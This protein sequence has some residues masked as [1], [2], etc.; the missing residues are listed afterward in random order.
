M[1]GEPFDIKFTGDPSD[2]VQAAKQVA[3][4]T[5]KIASAEG[6]RDSIIS[7]INAKLK[8]MA[9]AAAVAAI[10]VA[11]IG[12]NT[13]RKRIKEYEELSRAIEI[14]YEKAQEL[15]I[16]ERDAKLET[17]AIRS[18]IEGLAKAQAGYSPELRRLGFTIAEIRGLKPDE[19]FDA[20]SKKLNEGGLS[21]R[22]F[23]AAI[24]VLG[25][26]GES[27][28][29]AL[30]GGFE[31][32]R[33]I[34]RDSGKII[35]EETFG[36]LISNSDT[37]MAQFQ[38]MG[39]DI[40]KLATPFE[41]F[42]ELASAAIG[43]VTKTI[44]DLKGGVSYLVNFYGGLLGGLS[45]DEASDFAAVET[46]EGAESDAARTKERVDAKNR[47]RSARESLGGEQRS[48]TADILK[49]LEQS[50]SGG[51]DFG[52]LQKVGL[53]AGRGQSEALKLARQQNGKLQTLIKETSKQ[54]A[55]IDEKF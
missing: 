33:E 9:K 53:A 48:G 30:A 21:V 38:L 34:A 19:L 27:V 12:A 28:A 37:L 5:N 51:G 10:A 49:R 26:D 14:S 6:N 55:K 16:A 44:T 41:T 31:E 4:E 17:N 32:F 43:K 50:F 52:E 46:A 54:T 11:G 36:K 42:G 13:L 2:A 8:T 45:S 23:D 47:Q 40:I 20:L 3:T 7:G 1:A 25:K 29:L 35:S 24:N 18:A 15:A 39:E 22:Q